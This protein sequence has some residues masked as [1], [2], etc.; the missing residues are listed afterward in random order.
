[1]KSKCRISVIKWWSCK[2]YSAKCAVIRKYS[3]WFY[4]L[5]SVIRY[6]LNNK[7]TNRLAVAGQSIDKFSYFCGLFK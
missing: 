3:N 4:V 7:V 2:F 5:T 1:M 6:N